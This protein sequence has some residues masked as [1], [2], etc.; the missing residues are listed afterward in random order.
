MRIAIT[1]ASGVIGSALSKA[2]GKKHELLPVPRGTLPSVHEAADAL[3][4]A[5]GTY[6]RNW[7]E[8]IAVNLMYTINCVYNF[9]E[10]RKANHIVLLGGAGI[11][12]HN[13]S[14]NAEYAA[15]KAGLVAFA[16]SLSNKFPKASIN[17]VAP[18]PVKSKMNP[19]GGSPGPV[20]DFIDALLETQ[21]GFHS[22]HLYSAV[23]D[24][25]IDWRE[26]QGNL[27][28]LRRVVPE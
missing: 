3:I 23:H 14:E 11:G 16:E 18:G 10:V 12:G 27:Y 21:P 5:H 25:K 28:K 9:L 4:C 24:A 8:A 13:I 1:G 19:D 15:S 7:Q 22:G 20:C 26:Y 17:V 6:G 2:L